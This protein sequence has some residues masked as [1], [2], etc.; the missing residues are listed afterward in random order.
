MIRAMVVLAAVTTMFLAGPAGGRAGDD[1]QP[2]E[3]KPADPPGVLCAEFLFQ[4]AAFPQCHA[5]TIAETPSG[6]VVA[7]FGGTRE[8]RDD[9][10]IWAS[11][12]AGNGWTEPVEVANG[13]QDDGS[14]F[15]CWNPVLFRAADGQLLLLYKV[16]PSP[17]AWWGMFRR[18]HDDGNSW[19]PASRLPDGHLGPIKNKPVLLPDGRLLCGSSTEHA[20][21]C[22]HM[23]W[24]AD[25]GHTWQRTEPL[26]DGRSL[27]AIQPAI[28]LHGDGRVQI[29]CRTQQQRIAEAFSNDG[30]RTWS[31]LELT[32]LPNPNAGIDAVT[33][34]D[35][36]HLLVYNHTPRGRSPL[37]VALSKD[38]RSW[39][40]AVVLEDT[41][42]E[43]SYPAVIQTSDGLVHITY[44]WRRQRIK[45]VVLHPAQ[46]HLRPI[47]DGV[48]P[49]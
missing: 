11:R 43:Y 33:L 26:N 37:N 42:G 19:G 23:E 6:L 15:P 40:A 38:G 39:E 27:G 12:R 35:G 28:L 20:G 4:Q 5:S 14:R 30:G 24:T 16:G 31:K 34:A 45:H 18:S 1:R 25:W 41:P 3:S 8:G 36:R 13:L 9:V 49:E 2:T 32:E 47:R 22:V 7:W 29:L 44:T 48:W 10:G 17:S 21:W 46:L